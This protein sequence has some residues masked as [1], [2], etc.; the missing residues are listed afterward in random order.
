MHRGSESV[1]RW[2]VSLHGGHSGEFCDHAEGT[3]RQILEAAVAAG[4][5]TFGVSEHVPRSAERF[6]YAEERDRGWDMAKITADFER[7]AEVLTPLAEE[8]ADRLT[9]LRGFEAEV[10]PT[11]SYAEQV[12]GYRDRRLADGRPVFD[13]FVG[14]VHYVREHQ[15]DGPPANWA[16][17]AEA[18]GGPEAL[19]ICYY[20]T[21]AEMVEALHP[22]V[23]G[24]LDLIKRNTALAGFGDLPLDT[25]R[26]RQAA[27]SALEAVHAHGGILDLN[28]A[29]WRKGLGEPYPAS[30]LVQQAQ[31]MGVP[32]CFGDDSHR[33]DQVGEGLKEARLYLLQYGVPNITA[34]VREPS[35]AV[36]SP[37]IREIVEL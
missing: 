35:A 17:A 27:I 20:E 29:G 33:T 8:F 5:H 12:R 23:V 25:P 36:G 34:L 9:V 22:E 32:F 24:H 37:L 13:Y 10:I 11:D 4:Y 14:S 3:L 1:E 19:A 16:K 21:V 2:R 30:W 7:Y 15:I 31:A 18:L 26:I 6:L 28:T